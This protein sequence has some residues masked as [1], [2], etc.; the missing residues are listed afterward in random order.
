MKL[1]NRTLERYK[2]FARNQK[3]ERPCDNFGTH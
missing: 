2:L 3:E 1:R